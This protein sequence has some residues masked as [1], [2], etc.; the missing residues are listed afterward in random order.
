MRAMTRPVVNVAI[1][2]IAVLVLIV[3]LALFDSARAEPTLGLCIAGRTF[4]PDIVD[5]CATDSTPPE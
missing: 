5:I 4:E 3:F 2:T 1:G